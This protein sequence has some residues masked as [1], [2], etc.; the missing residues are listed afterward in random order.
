MKKIQQAFN[1]AF[2]E[3]ETQFPS[4]GTVELHE[5]ERAGADNGAGSERQFAYC[6]DG[7][8][9]IIAFAPKAAELSE[10]RLKGLMRHEFGH[11]LEYRYGVKELEKR[12]GR[13]LPKKVERRADV[14]A[15]WVWGQ[16]IV[17]DTSDI[18]CVGGHGKKRRPRRLPDTVEVLRANPG[19]LAPTGLLRLYVWQSEYGGVGRFW[20]GEGIHAGLAFF[21]FGP[22]AGGWSPLQHLP[23]DRE[24][25]EKEAELCAQRARERY[26]V[27]VEIVWGAPEERD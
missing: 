15:E 23:R 22:C 9:I 17:Y 12:L 20:E 16:P 7:D 24:R 21:T 13:K 6:A 27:D 2:N 4:L 26:G 10:S 18:Q 5:D 19:H 11:A 14:I 3:I 25:I 1:E 8:P